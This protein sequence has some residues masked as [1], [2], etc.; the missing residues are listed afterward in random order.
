MK[1]EHRSWEEIFEDLREVV[2]SKE[3]EAELKNVRA[4]IG[5]FIKID[6]SMCMSEVIDKF[7][8]HVADNFEFFEDIRKLLL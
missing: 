4:S 3:K 8:K 6:D 1:V 2:F 5:F 7:E